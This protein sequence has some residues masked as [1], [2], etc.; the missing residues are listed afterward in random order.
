MTTEKLRL[1]LGCGP[2]IREGYVNIDARPLPGAVQGDVSALNFGPG[3]V[4]EI[5]ASDILE[6]FSYRRTEEVLGHW[7]SRLKPGGILEL[8]VPGLDRL[9]NLWSSS[10]LASDYELSYYIFGGQEYPEN[11][12]L[13][14]FTKRGLEDFLPRFGLTI[15]SIEENNTN[16]FVRARKL[17]V[18]PTL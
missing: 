18:A 15:E 8:R 16:W 1:N 5:Y 12:H 6:H 9:F 14:G 11:T 2:D 13:A 10:K 3:T 17:D 7:C 4:D